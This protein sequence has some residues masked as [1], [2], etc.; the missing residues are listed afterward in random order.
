MNGNVNHPRFKA[1]AV[2]SGP[3]LKDAPEWFD[4]KA[5]VDKSTSMIAE[6][7]RN[8]ARLVVFP[9]CWLPCF[10]YW[11]FDFTDLP[12]YREL[13][14]AYLWN[15][16][17]VPGPET[18]ALG[19]AAKKANAYVTLGINERDKDFQGRMYNSIL[20]LGPDGEILG[21]HRKICNTF[22]ERLF[23]TPGDGGDNLKAVYKTELGYL[24]GSICGEHSQFTLMYNWI[25]QRVQVHC[26][27]WPGTVTTKVESDIS[28]R[29]VCRA[30][31]AFGVLSS[32]YFREQ[33]L[34]R[35]FY[36]N[37]AFNIPGMICG[38]SGIVNPWGEYIAGPVYNEETIVYG[39]IDLAE[40]DKARFA[41][42]LTGA[43]SRWDLLSL[44][45]NQE[46]YQ[47][48]KS[49]KPAE[50]DEGSPVSNRVAELEA[51]LQQLE[52]QIDA[53]KNN[54]A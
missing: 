34:P 44:N 24:G 23:H 40:I 29:A 18:E 28:T 53:L 39:D 48:F 52:E 50:T 38:G 17:E 30:A 42:N 37:S 10:T 36:K 9:E 43:Y 31:H 19:Q 5:S 11:G 25:M 35:Q 22:G 32:G 45:V 14:A 3:V 46:T 21:I 4:L 54:R 51:R 6:A 41:V 33:D 49:M 12:T 15:S 26:S 13:W 47:P 1:A 16:I 27:I 20:Y 7:G 2:Q 8:G